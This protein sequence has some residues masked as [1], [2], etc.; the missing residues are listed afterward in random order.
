MKEKRSVLMII[1]ALLLALIMLMS[2]I[3]IQLTA[4]RVTYAAETFTVRATSAEKDKQAERAIDGDPFTYWQ[5][6]ASD[7]APELIADLGEIVMVTGYKQ[8]F[9][10]ADVWS[11]IVY[12]SMDG[13]S[14]MPIADYATGAAGKVFADSASGFYR[15]VKISFLASEKAP[16]TSCIFDVEYEPLSKGS[17]VALG[18]KGYSGSWSAGFEHEKAFDGDTGSYYCANDGSLPQWCGVTWEYPCLINGITVFQQD[19]ATYEFEVF[20]TDAEGVTHTLVPRERR[21]GAEFSFPCSGL[22]TK[23]EYKIYAAPGW[24]NLAELYVYGF[25]DLASD[26]CATAAQRNSEGGATVYSF[27]Y[28]AYVDSVQ[29]GGKVSIS[30]DGNDW[31]DSAAQVGKLC[32]FVKVEGGTNTRLYA[33]P[34]ERDLAFGLK[35]AVSDYSNES[36]NALKCTTNPEHEDGRNAYWCAESEGGEHWLQLD[37]GNVCYVEEVVQQFQ[38]EGNYQFKVEASRDGK[39]WTMLHDGYGTYEH[40]RRFT[41][42]TAAEKMF[43]YVRLSILDSGWANSNQFQVIG[44]GDPIPE[45]WWQRESGVVRYYPKEQKVTIK[46]MTEKLEYYHANGFKVIEVHQPYEGAGDIWSGLGATDNYNA[47]P[48]NGTLDDWAEFLDRAHSLGMYAFMFGNVGYTRSTSPFFKKACLDYANGIASEERDWFL[49][50]ETCPDPTKWFWSDTA[51]AYYYGYW[52]ENGQ[53]PNYNFNNAA[54]QRESKRYV[55]FWADFGFDGVAL[56]A[57]PAYYFGSVDPSSVTYE[58]IT[59]PLNARNIMIL[60]EGTGDYNYIHSYHYTT[61]QNYN[62]GNWGGGA[63]SLG[64]DAVT[65]RNAKTVDDFIKSGRD[66]AVS[67]GGSAIAPLSFEQK[68]ENVEDYKRKAEA[69][70]LTTSGHMAFLHSGSSGFVGQDII[71]ERWSDDLKATVFGL[72]ALQNGYAAF[73]ATGMRYR[74]PTNNDDVYYAYCRGDMRGGTRA[75]VVFNYS[76]S[77]AKVQVDLSATGLGGTFL[78]LVRG[79]LVT[80]AGKGLELTIPAGS[81]VILGQF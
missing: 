61:I 35:G 71:E 64:I 8:V 42:K 10:E 32:N 79:E 78:D 69:A 65:D 77:Q 48:V 58:S 17:N 30:M 76:A 15:Y 66:N 28:G 40:G 13:E 25:R 5:A 38:D 73:N 22:F 53:I 72:F 63:W 4:R 43:R 81:Y 37:L 33:L 7:E 18:M 45:S 36:F 70:L 20:G 16:F 54:W 47:D 12:G 1:A 59:K 19:Y 55:T 31:Q 27:P 74:V 49:F 51:N 50:S 24:A 67:L 39:A 60:P 11:F 6:E 62:M 57:P 23:I 14:W 46:E 21:T 52:G 3:P 80:G 41:I 29:G 34:L 44:Y 26:K 9:R 56:D 68:Y 75:V 2:M